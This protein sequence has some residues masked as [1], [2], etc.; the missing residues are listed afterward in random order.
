MILT[1]LSCRFLVSSPANILQHNFTFVNR[2][3]KESREKAKRYRQIEKAITCVT[4]EEYAV[5]TVRGNETEIHE[6]QPWFMEMLLS[7]V[8]QALFVRVYV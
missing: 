2:F 7:T 1:H 6:T 4:A 5:Y 3:H 8:L